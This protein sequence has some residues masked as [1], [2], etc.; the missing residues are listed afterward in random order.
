[1]NPNSIAVREM[2]RLLYGDGHILSYGALGTPESVASITLDDVKQW[3]VTN[4]SPNLAVLH[5]AGAI[6]VAATQQAIAGLISRWE[7]KNLAIPSVP[8]ARQV[9]T[10]G[11][12]FYDVPNASQSVLRIG[13]LA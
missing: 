9:R 7:N 3:F 12:Y 6:D 2:N 1:A 4:V 11:V 5:V 10:P 13:Y 8:E